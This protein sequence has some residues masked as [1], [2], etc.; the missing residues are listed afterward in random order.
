MKNK[1]IKFFG[2]YTKEDFENF[3]NKE[4]FYDIDI[5]NKKTI[6][7]KYNDN[8]LSL[9]HSFGI[10]FTFDE[11]SPPVVINLTR[12]NGTCFFENNKFIELVKEALQASEFFI[13][14]KTTQKRYENVSLHFN[15]EDIIETAFSQNSIQIY[16]GKNKGKIINSF[17]E[18]D[19]RYFIDEDTNE[20]V[21]LENIAFVNNISIFDNLFF[22]LESAK[23]NSCKTEEDFI[24]KFLNKMRENE[25]FNNPEFLSKIYRY[26]RRIDDFL[27]RK[28]YKESNKIDLVKKDQEIYYS[29]LQFIEKQFIL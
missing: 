17:I 15:P 6:D 25:P 16:E 8:Q 13:T 23:T 24:N 2:G 29:V 28:L 18:N 1:I 7:T 26:H 11:K 4:A 27:I 12:R 3:Q 10:K 5:I 20:K 9:M 19:K 21:C 22:L 14:D